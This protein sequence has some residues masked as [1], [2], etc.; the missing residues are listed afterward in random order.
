M[1]LRGLNF[2][3]GTFAIL[4]ACSAHET[5]GPVT[6][7]VWLVSLT[8]PVST[9]KVKDTVVIR[10]QALDRKGIPLDTHSFVWKSE[11][12]AVATVDQNGVVL[13]VSAGSAV[14][15]A[16]S[17]GIGGAFTVAVTPLPV[18]T[19]VI[20]TTPVFVG[21]SIQARAVTVNP[22]TKNLFNAP[23]K[24]RSSD[25]AVARIDSATGLL[26]TLAVG[27]ARIDATYEGLTGSIEV[28]VVAR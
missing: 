3:V 24:W 8:A 26:E 2:A 11:N 22:A 4:A 7:S 21:I 13:G 20:S 25:P 16:S 1:T 12:T 17:E 6:P 23:A 18:L 14:I 15:T 9:I 19:L 5:D 28:T 27:T 10:A